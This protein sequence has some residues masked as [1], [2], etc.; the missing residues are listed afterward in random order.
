MS[1]HLYIARQPML[2]RNK[3]IFA[4]D[5]LYRDDN[6]SSDISDNRFATAAVLV[7]ALNRF[8][9]KN[10]VG[11]HPAF[12]KVDHTFVLHDMMLSIPK[13]LFVFSL[14]ESIEMTP[15]LIERVKELYMQ[16]YRF[17]INDLALNSDTLEKFKPLLE[18]MSY[19]KIDTAR[20]DKEYIKEAL[21]HLKEYPAQLVATKVET[22]EAYERF[23]EMGAEY[24][25]GYYFA[26]PNILE[27]NRL[28]PDQFSIIRLCNLLMSDAGIDEITAAFEENHA[29][30][31]QL[32][33]FINSG[34]FHFQKEIAS[35]HHILTL[36]GRKPLAQWLMLMIYAKS[37]A[38]NDD[39]SPLLLM[40]KN[41][42]EI[43]TNVLKMVQPDAKSN[44][45][46]EA[47]FVGVLSLMDALLGIPLETILNELH[48]A[49]GVKS[50]LE[51]RT[52]IL[53]EIYSLVLDI[54]HFETGKIDDFMIR[55]N[56]RVDAIEKLLVETIENVNAFE[57][58]VDNDRKVT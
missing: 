52:G 29:V 58:S 8:G 56:L 54:E 49:Q 18:L 40:V 43:M 21:V 39:R 1:G 34:A 57:Q 31:L 30:T 28:D 13:E 3:T 45:L 14:L 36:V 48:V 32:L 24:F 22:L 35:I 23:L 25:Q 38:K 51:N 16:G 4:Y 55:H 2:D 33:Q 50:A 9:I 17:A 44:L 26:K 27:G 11:E 6:L 7:N 53:G 19:F 47:Y 5:L 20:S 42:T 12:I 41:R 15:K 46:G 37:V 10:I